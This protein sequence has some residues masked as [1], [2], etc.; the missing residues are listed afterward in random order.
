MAKKS[1]ALIASS[2]QID[3]SCS[4]D[5]TSP[6]C[7]E[8]ASSKKRRSVPKSEKLQFVHFSEM[9]TFW[10]AKKFCREKGMRLAQETD[11]SILESQN[12]PAGENWVNPMELE[13]ECGAACYS[14]HNSEYSRFNLHVENWK[15]K[16]SFRYRSCSKQ[17]FFICETTEEVLTNSCA[18]PVKYQESSRPP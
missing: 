13:S 12:F 5:D 18:P 9:K 14:W 4:E 1:N 8:I 10:D 3:I 16:P 7:I 6:H 17:L 15:N 11:Q 2:T